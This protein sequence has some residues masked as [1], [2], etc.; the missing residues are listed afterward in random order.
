MQA[1]RNN[2]ERCPNFSKL[3]GL[4]PIEVILISQI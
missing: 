1:Q 3:D 2:M 4:S